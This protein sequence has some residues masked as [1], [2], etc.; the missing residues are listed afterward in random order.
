MQTQSVFSSVNAALLSE[1]EK[2]TLP[3]RRSWISGLPAN[4]ITGHVYS[5]I[6]FLT[7][8]L[9]YITRDFSSPYFLTLL[10]AS[11]K[12]FRI[13]NGAKGLPVYFYKISDKAEIND[14]TGEQEIRR[15]TLL[16]HSH[17]FNVSDVVGYEIPQPV[18]AVPSRMWNEIRKVHHPV[19]KSNPSRCFYSASPQ[20]GYISLPPVSSFFCEEEYFSALFH[21]VVHWTGHPSRLNRQLNEET[22]EVYAF[23]ELVAEIGASYLLGMCG[24]QNTLSNSAAY[25]YHWL[26]KA[27]GDHTYI[28]RA[29]RYAQAAVNYLI[30]SPSAGQA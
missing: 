16:R 10:Q 4:L 2:G 30:S 21:E 22:G 18:L 24:I 13:R 29:A 9:S 12:G 23:E 8:S 14:Q 28:I 5:G 11:K 17:L 1:I 27:K 20:E 7:L 19:M 6:N 26:E 15:V 25:I 3:W